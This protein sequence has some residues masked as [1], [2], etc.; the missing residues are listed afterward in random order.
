MGVRNYAVLLCPELSTPSLTL[1]TSLI[2]LLPLTALALVTAPLLSLPVGA[3]PLTR[4]SA[5][6]TFVDGLLTSLMRTAI[7]VRRNVSVLTFS[8][9]VRVP[10]HVRLMVSVELRELVTLR[11]IPPRHR[12]V[13][14]FI[15]IAVLC[16]TILI[17]GPV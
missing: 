1:L 12:L 7:P 6:T 10:V 9:L 14:R 4:L 8:L 13:S 3:S 17:R 16:G 15:G 5:H 11:L 2:P